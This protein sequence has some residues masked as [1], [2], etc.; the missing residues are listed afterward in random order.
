MVVGQFFVCSR[1]RTDPGKCGRNY[2]R[3]GHA[4]TSNIF[5][6][7]I[8]HHHRSDR[9]ECAEFMRVP[10]R[11][12]Q[13]AMDAIT[14]THTIRPRIVAASVAFVLLSAFT[15]IILVYDTLDPWE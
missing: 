8:R 4:P 1:R 6:L 2:Y 7:Y 15:D 10:G 11:D 3:N 14:H 5:T 12:H 13:G 9:E